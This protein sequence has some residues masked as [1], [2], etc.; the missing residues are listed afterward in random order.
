MLWTKEEDSILEGISRKDS[1]EFKLLTKLKGI[2]S[3]KK[4]VEYNSIELPFKLT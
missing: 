3:I 4:R 1:S 2:E